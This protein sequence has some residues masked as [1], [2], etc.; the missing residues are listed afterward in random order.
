MDSSNKQEWEC[1]KA[2]LKKRWWGHK[3]ENAK[4][5]NDLGFGILTIAKNQ[6][7]K[8]HLPKED[9]IIYNTSETRTAL[10]FQKYLLEKEMALYIAK[11]KDAISN[12]KTNLAL[13]EKIKDNGYAFGSFLGYNTENIEYYYKY[14]T[15]RKTPGNVILNKENTELAP[16]IN[17]WILTNPAW[18]TQYENDKNEYNKWME[19]N[20]NLTDNTL[21]KQNNALNRALLVLNYPTEDIESIANTPASMPQK[22]SWWRKTALGAGVLTAG[23]ALYAYFKGKK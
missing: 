6:Y 14:N 19:L 12:T 16:L 2:G 15:Y 4:K 7:S 22:T 20:E 5:W 23:A 21:I 3:I 18:K 10:L 9:Y 11:T 13:A 17:A 1:L 8:E